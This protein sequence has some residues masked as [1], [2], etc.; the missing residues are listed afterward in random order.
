MGME[1]RLHF[2]IR[3]C[4]SADRS[5]RRTESRAWV[6]TKLSSLR[7]GYAI[8]ARDAEWSH[9]YASV[10]RP[11]TFLSTWSVLRSR[12]R[13]LL[14]VPR[15]PRDTN[16]RTA[17]LAKSSLRSRRSRTVTDRGAGST[18]DHPCEDRPRGADVTAADDRPARR[19]VTPPRQRK[20]SRVQDVDSRCIHTVSYTHL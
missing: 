4:P 17:N 1:K 11:G 8:D 7:P 20:A 5:Q 16:R 19:C 3:A 13:R 15:R 6:P 9:R 2:R 10:A 18:R 12:R 14:H